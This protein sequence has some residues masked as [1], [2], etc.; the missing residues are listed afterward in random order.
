MTLQ[1]KDS[2]AIVR[3]LKTDEVSGEHVSY[4][5]LYTGA[6]TIGKLAANSGV[7]I[8]DVDVTSVVPG[9]AASNLGKAEDAVHGSG[10]VGV[11]ALTVRKDTAAALAG[12]DG[13]YQPLITDANGRLHV[14]TEL[15][16]TTIEVVGDAPHDAAA[17]GNPV[18]IGGC[19][20]NSLPA[21]VSNGDAVRIVAD[22]F[23]RLVVAPFTMPEK[24][25]KYASAA[26]ITDTADDEVFAAV[27]GTKHCI[28]SI[29]ASCS[30]ASTGTYIVVK[31]GS[32][33]IFVCYA[34]PAGG[35]FTVNFP[36]P[37]VGTANTAINVA[38]ITNGSATRVSISGFQ[39]PG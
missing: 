18:L 10:D 1:I 37:L 13:D 25:E 35:G 30:H 15:S 21:T 6:N 38:N 20:S 36:V 29:T 4:H 22:L 34:G 24:Y 26:D 11:M 27:A 39:I 32:T 31:D 28:T 16:A 9:T 3:S 12:T 14:Q 8:G 2:S 7:D 19:A 5:I 33:V 23:G 17:A